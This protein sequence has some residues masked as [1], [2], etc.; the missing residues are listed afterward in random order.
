MYQRMRLQM[1]FC[2]KTLATPLKV[3]LEGSI[4]CMGPHMGLQITCL[5]K[6]LHTIG[7]RTE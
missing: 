4:S 1:S 7:K 5:V 2:Y 6:E 3:T